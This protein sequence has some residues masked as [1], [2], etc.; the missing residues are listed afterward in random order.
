MTF[1]DICNAALGLIGRANSMENQLAE[2]EV[3]VEYQRT[4]FE[5]DSFSRLSWADAIH[6][7][8]LMPD[9]TTVRK[10]IEG[11][12]TIWEYLM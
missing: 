6:R 7:Y 2:Y 11:K 9:G 8:N 3:W 5:K 4:D 12:D 1:Q 10:R